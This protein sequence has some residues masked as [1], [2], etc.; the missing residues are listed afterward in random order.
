V[1]DENSKVIGLDENNFHSAS[2]ARAGGFI[3]G[4]FAPAKAA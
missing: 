3:A 1:P 2:F 4:W